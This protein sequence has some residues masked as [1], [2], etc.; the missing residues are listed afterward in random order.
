VSDLKARL[1]KDLGEAR[2]SRDKFRTLVLSTTLSELRNRE[3]DERREVGD[4]EVQEVVSRAIKQRRDAAEQMRSGGRP[5]LAEKEEA[6][7]EL[8]KAY[9]PEQLSPDEVRAMI[10]EIVEGGATAM[11]AVMGQLMPRIKGRFDGKEANGLVREA[12]EG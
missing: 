1:Q 10:R 11:G 2:K 7:A 3:I 4:A 9:L 12:L 6:E 5:E 8:L